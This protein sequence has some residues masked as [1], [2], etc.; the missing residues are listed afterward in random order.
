MS[1]ITTTA[2]HVALLA[3]VPLVHLESGSEMKGRVAFGS[4]A[5]ETFRKLDE[6]R[7][8][9][10]VDVYIYAS[11]DPN[12]GPEVSWHAKYICQIENGKADVEQFRPE[13]TKTDTNDSA[14]FWIVEDLTLLAH[15]ERMP[16]SHLT[17]YGR[18]KAYG[19]AFS[20]EGPLLIE[21]P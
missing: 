11:H 10:H 7:K 17:G 3:P 13:S 19:H 21:H 12:G 14:V 1:E 9:M 4:R 15:T 8:G 16:V 6:L 2:T 18:K 20:P 5:W